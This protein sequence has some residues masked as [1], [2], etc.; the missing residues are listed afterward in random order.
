MKIQ[1]ITLLSL[2]CW[3]FISIHQNELIAQERPNESV[4]QSP[5]TSLWLGTYGRFRLGEKLYWDAQFH[6]RTNEF[7]GTPYIGRLAQIYNRHGL[8]YMVTPN[9]SVTL[10]PVLRLNFNQNPG[11]PNFTSLRL[12]PRIWHEYLFSMPFKRLTLFHRLRFEHRWSRGNAIDADWIYRDRWRYKIFAN[13]PLNTRKMQPGT[14][15]FTPDVE[16]IMQSGKPV[17]DSPLED[18]R[19]NPTIGYI[20]NPRVKY[21]ASM[22]YT[23]GQQLNRGWEY[24]SR[25]ILR[26]N[27]YVSLDF[28]KFEEKVQET[29]IED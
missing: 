9:F 14:F 2:V 29:K 6:Y 11:N 4:I 22:M 3:L 23:T 16:I 12:E 18:L 13:I 5:S 1:K 7:D 17:V 15:F 19:I 21:T 8:N 26:L 24:N 10:G 25:W 27:V 28:R 20:A